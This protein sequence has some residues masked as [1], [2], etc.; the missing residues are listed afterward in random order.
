[1][2]QTCL[3][4]I[5]ALTLST[6]AFAQGRGAAAP[7]PPLEA[8]ASQADVDLALLAAPANLKDQATVIK[9]NPADWTYTTL[10][11]GTNRL[12]CF[13]KSGL[14]GQLPFSIECTSIANLDRARQNMRFET[15]PDRAKRQ[16]A[17]DAAEADGTR[18][19]PE[20]GSIWYHLMGPSREQARTHM[21]IA[22][23]GATGNTLG[24]PENAREGRVWV[25]NP[26]TSTAHL[27]VPGE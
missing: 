11:K 7:P 22:V 20:F 5:A 4:A 1:M 2:K 10:R 24:L 18:A 6:A 25:M 26:G 14:P 13:D 21:T 23:P 9:W 3:L 27:M 17:L 16:A 8:G 12:L 15:E 19:K